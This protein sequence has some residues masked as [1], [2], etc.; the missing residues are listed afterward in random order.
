MF[1]LPS[2]VVHGFLAIFNWHFNS[3]AVVGKIQRQ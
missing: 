2:T 3:K 1:P